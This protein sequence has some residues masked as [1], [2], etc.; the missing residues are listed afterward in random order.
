M[1]SLEKMRLIDF[2]T[3]KRQRTMMML[4][5][6][7]AYKLLKISEKIEEAAFMLCMCL[8][9]NGKYNYDFHQA[10]LLVA[11]FKKP[12]GILY[13]YKEMNPETFELL[14]L[15]CINFEKKIKKLL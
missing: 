15:E 13:P 10:K 5:N 1:S 7:D 6:A 4:A 9:S 11:K 2:L 14:I 12:N 3:K 8:D